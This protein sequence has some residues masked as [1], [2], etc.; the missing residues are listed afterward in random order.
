VR[1]TTSHLLSL[2]FAAY[3]TLPNSFRALILGNPYSA[4]RI[5][6]R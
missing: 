2:S 1:L 6:I 4:S 3:S 5:L